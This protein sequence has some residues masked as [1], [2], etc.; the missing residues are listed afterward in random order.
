[1]KEVMKT[2][3]YDIE[4]TKERLYYFFKE[5]DDLFKEYHQMTIEEY[6]VNNDDLSLDESKKYVKKY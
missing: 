2:N 3:L 1:M 4:D 5:V 6:L